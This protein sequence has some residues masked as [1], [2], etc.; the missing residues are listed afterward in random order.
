[1]TLL[2]QSPARSLQRC[3]DALLSD[4]QTH[5]LLASY[6]VR[7]DARADVWNDKKLA[8]LFV[9][10]A[11]ASRFLA[12]KD[13]IRRCQALCRYWRVQHK[14]SSAG[15]TRQRLILKGLLRGRESLRAVTAD[16]LLRHLIADQIS[17]AIDSL[18]TPADHSSAE[19]T[20][21]RQTLARST[22]TANALRF[23]ADASVADLCRPP[24]TTRELLG[25]LF[26]LDKC[27][28]RNDSGAFIPVTFTREINRC[29]ERLCAPNTG[30]A[31]V[32]GEQAGLSPASSQSLW[33][34]QLLASALLALSSMIQHRPVRHFFVVHCQGVLWASAK[35]LF[36]CQH[37][38]S[39]GSGSIRQVL[40]HALLISSGTFYE[41]A[42]DAHGAGHGGGMVND[43]DAPLAAG[44]AG[45]SA[46]SGV[47]VASVASSASGA[48]APLPV[49]DRAAVGGLLAVIADNDGTQADWTAVS[50]RLYRL[51]V[52]L[53]ML[54]SGFGE[55]PLDV[56][57]GYEL[58]R[59]QVLIASL[60][61][62][63]NHCVQLSVVGIEDQTCLLA[64]L[65]RLAG[66]LTTGEDRKTDDDPNVM[67]LL[68]NSVTLTARLGI[69]AQRHWQQLTLELDAV[70]QDFIGYSVQHV[71][72]A[73]L[74][75]LPG[76]G[77]AA[78][79]SQIVPQDMLHDLRLLLK[80]SRIL[81]VQRIES[82]VL[83][84]TE[85]YQEVQACP[86]FAD[87]A[88]LRK[89]LPR[90]HRSLCR[91]LDQAAAWQ[92]PGNARRMIN[93]L[94]GCL[95]RW[96]GANGIGKILTA[97]TVSER[98]AGT[99]NDPWRLCLATNRRL[100][101]LLRH[102]DD[103]DSVRVLLL[104]LLRSQEDLIRRK[105]D[106]RAGLDAP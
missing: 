79:D 67:D 40:R 63:A 46:A 84:M 86:E 97:T 50:L 49:S 45:V 38:A 101:K 36:L 11:G 34:L 61:A 6:R 42:S 4:I 72:A 48:L 29:I 98:S 83:V 87:V 60:H 37:C 10:L 53:R 20:W 28:R 12:D 85:V 39:A 22:A 9:Q 57:Q 59:W 78:A 58:E 41:P 3:L 47:S 19:Q 65:R 13:A 66:I 54:G 82:F 52:C 16:R 89:A 64:L 8:A 2:N 7:D 18:T 76:I 90:A 35:A 73:E 77:A 68:H 5:C 31:A 23:L 88:D 69:R 99:D 30:S 25:W 96:R 94:Y 103:L 24:D 44:A 17:A 70:Q 92:A 100:R 27:L 81:N 105:V 51:L 21:L 74:R 95:D 33:Q 56:T 102:H 32:Q 62:S 71:L 75:C 15:L 1:M 55:T 91:M 26:A 104:E 14:S 93:T 106:Y 80:G 43:V